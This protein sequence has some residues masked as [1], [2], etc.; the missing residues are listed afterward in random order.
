M[1][2]E[3]YQELSKKFNDTQVPKDK[4]ILP[5]FRP[6]TTNEE[7]QPSTTGQ[8]KSNLQTIVIAAVV[9]VAIILV[10]RFIKK[11]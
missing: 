8:A 7:N 11:H 9:V 3:R 2:Y 1:T 4:R 5:Q 6:E 10:I